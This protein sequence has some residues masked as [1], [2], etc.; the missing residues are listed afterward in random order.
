[1]GC[2]SYRPPFAEGIGRTEGAGSGRFLVCKDSP[3]LS[4]KPDDSELIWCSI[5]EPA[6]LFPLTTDSS[7][8]R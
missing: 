1:M 6:S 8:L 2:G 4:F 7:W 5:F 3:T